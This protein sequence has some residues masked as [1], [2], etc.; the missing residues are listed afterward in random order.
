MS[1]TND[2]NDSI[3]AK[4]ISKGL[5]IM[6]GC[7]AV[8]ALAY[9][10]HMFLGGSSFDDSSTVNA[11]IAPAQKVYTQAPET[12]EPVQS[13]PQVVD[14]DDDINST[15]STAPISQVDTTLSEYSLLTNQLNLLNMKNQIS[16]SKLQLTKSN[17]EL[18]SLLPSPIVEDDTSPS[19]IVEDDTSPSPIVEDDTSTK[20]LSVGVIYTL[21]GDMHALLSTPDGKINVVVGSMWGDGQYTVTDIDS[22]CVT[23][24]QTQTSLIGDQGDSFTSDQSNLFFQQHI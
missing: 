2:Y 21:N 10:G 7:V 12:V 14:S 1:E 5:L 8:I 17:L 18:A 4:P 15:K 11:A 22:S 20:T 19:P 24:S 3:K 9:F 16:T 13:N 6:L 23:Y